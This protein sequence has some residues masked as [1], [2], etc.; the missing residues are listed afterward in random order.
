V[1]GLAEAPYVANLPKVTTLSGA[2]CQNYYFPVYDSPGG[3]TVYKV[4]GQ[5][6]T[7]DPQKLGRQPAQILVNGGKYNH[8]YCDCPYDPERYSYVRYATERGCTTLNIDRLAY[9]LSDHPSASTLNFDVAG[10][11]T[12]QLVGYLRQAGF[13][14]CDNG[15]RAGLWEELREAFPPAP[16]PS[17]ISLRDLKE[18]MLFIE[19][20]EAIKCLDEGVIESVADADVGSILGIGFPGSTGG[21]LQYVNGYEHP[22]YG[23]GP[24]AFLARARALAR[25][26]GERFEPPLRSSRRLSAAN[27][28]RT[29]PLR[30]LSEVSPNESTDVPRRGVAV[31]FD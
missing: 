7:S 29:S 11:V 12:H 4:F 3:T 8:A 25:T 10:Y 17:A 23:I 15:N 27:A 22:V 26:Y 30:P 1:S 28:M 2:A 20:I 14:N 16:D 21:A 6:C 31:S 9:G 18:R 24:A 13:Y 19:S 5:L